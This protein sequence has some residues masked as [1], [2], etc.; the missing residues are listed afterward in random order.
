M[1]VTWLMYITLSFVIM[2]L[3]NQS[4]ANPPEEKK[5]K[6]TLFLTPSGLAKLEEYR[7]FEMGMAKKYKTIGQALDELLIKHERNMKAND[8]W[9]GVIIGTVNK[10]RKIMEKRI[11]RKSEKE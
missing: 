11:A 7:L 3:E 4:E 10:G 6:V 2:S 9:T 1:A 8:Y 5:I